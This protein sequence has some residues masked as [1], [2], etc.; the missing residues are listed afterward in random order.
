LFSTVLGFELRAGA[1]SLEPL[2][3]PFFALGIF[4]IG[5]HELFAW[6]GFKPWSSWSLCLNPSTF[7][8]KAKQTLI[9]LHSLSISLLL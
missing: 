8:L 1:L 3:Q 6:A 7:F 2:H 5:S 4:H 9:F